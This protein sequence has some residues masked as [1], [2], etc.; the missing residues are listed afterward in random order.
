MTPFLIMAAV[1]LKGAGFFSLYYYAKAFRL[2]VQKRTP[3]RFRKVLTEEDAVLWRKTEGKICLCWATLLL[4]GQMLLLIPS[5]WA[6]SAVLAVF[7]AAL[8]LGCGL[9][10][11]NNL[12]YRKR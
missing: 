12:R 1:V 6:V 5:I 11:R 2:L 8:F 4:A 3:V 9:R 10:V 7:L